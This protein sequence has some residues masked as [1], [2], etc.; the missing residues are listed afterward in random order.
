MTSGPSS[1]MRWSITGT[2]ARLVHACIAVALSVS[3]G[4]NLRRSTSVEDSARPSVKCAKPHEWNIGAAIIV[5]PRARSGIFENSAAAGSS[6]SGCL[7]DALFGVPVVPLVRMRTR[8]FSDGGVR[9]D[10]SPEAMRSSS[11]GTSGFSSPS[12][13]PMNVRRP[14]AASAHSSANSSS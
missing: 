8:P 7:R 2:T 9:S 1:R 10:A 12:N 3:S 14:S 4:S 11:S 13:Q 6:D 5:L